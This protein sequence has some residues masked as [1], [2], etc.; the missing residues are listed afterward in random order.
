MSLGTARVPDRGLG[1]FVDRG[2]VTAAFVGIG[3]AVTIGVSFLLVI[4]IEPVY[5]Y[6]SVPAGLLIGYY[7][8]ARSGTR[9]GAWGRIL[10]NAT[11]AGL[12]TG[13][14]LAALLLG[15]KAL[16]FY[17]DGGYPDFNRIDPET[18]EP[19]PPFC[20]SGAGCV[21]ARYLAGDTGA[22]FAA[23]GVDDVGE[24]TSLYWAQ[25]W[26]T[27]GLLLALSAGFGVAGGGLYRISR[28]KSG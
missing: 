6:L 12:A 22:D 14:T 4:P 1:R 28:P 19:I 17:A 15:V 7:A 3:M 26:S 27:A 9:R 20:E 21:Y 18:R 24:F 25:Q 13:L 16:F 5:W 23:A 10:A 11:F 8:N 2:A